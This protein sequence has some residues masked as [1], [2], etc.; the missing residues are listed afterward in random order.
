LPAVSNLPENSGPPPKKH[1]KGKRLSGRLF[2]EM[3]SRLFSWL[4]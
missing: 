2:S 4:V 3:L 1:Q